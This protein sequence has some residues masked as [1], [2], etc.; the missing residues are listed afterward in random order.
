MSKKVREYIIKMP[1]SV[2]EWRKAQRY[3]LAK[4][5]TEEVT[6][7]KHQKTKDENMTK[8]E[9]H[10][11]INIVKRLPSVIGKVIG[12]KAFCIDEYSTNL[13]LAFVVK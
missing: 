4:Y 6:I 1:Y 13:D 7:I 5:T 11:F 9:T 12:G 8:T 3:V 10:K 2:S